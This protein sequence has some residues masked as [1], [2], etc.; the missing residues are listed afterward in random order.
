MAKNVEKKELSTKQHKMIAA[1]LTSRN[2]GEAC[3]ATQIA[4]TTL[5]RWLLDP[6]FTKALKGAEDDS[7]NSSSRSFLAGQ[8]QARETIMQVMTSGATDA[9]R[10][11][12]ANDWLGNLFKYRELATLEN[13]VAALEERLSNGD[14]KNQN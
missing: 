6:M 10:L 12:A 1:L 9:I 7:I 4:R 3:T 11:K 13:R 2:I 14:T 5:S 8:E